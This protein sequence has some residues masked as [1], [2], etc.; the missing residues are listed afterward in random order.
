M[1]HYP[2]PSLMSSSNS[3]LRRYTPPTC[4]L[5][6]SASGSPLSRWIGRP[7]LKQL[8]FQLSLDDP[9]LPEEKRVTLKGDKTQLEALREAVE[10]Y[11]QD[12]LGQSPDISPGFLPDLA[13]D[14]T[15]DAT[16]DETSEVPATTSENPQ[17]V[18]SVEVGQVASPPTSLPALPGNIYLQSDGMLAHNLYLGSLATPESGQVIS[19][20]TLQLFDLATAFE[21]YAEE[22]V[23][24]PHLREHKKGFATKLKTAP[25]W[26]KTAAVLVLAGGASA[27][28]LLLVNRNT[29]LQTADAPPASPAP[30]PTEQSPIAGL[31]SPS[32]TLVVPTPPLSSSQILPSPTLGAGGSPSPGLTPSPNTSPTP[33]AGVT[34]SP[35]ASPTPAAGT[36]GFGSGVTPSSPNASPGGA[37]PAGSSPNQSY[38]VPGLQFGTRGSTTGA[39]PPAKPSPQPRNDAERSRNVPSGGTLPRGTLS[40]PTPDATT[41]PTN[42]V[43]T[44]PNRVAEGNQPRTNR[45]TPPDNSRFFSR[46]ETTPKAT[47]SPASDPAATSAPTIQPPP[48]LPTP[49]PARPT[50][51]PLPESASP[52]ATPTPMAAAP[53]TIARLTPTPRA[54]NPDPTVAA[55]RQPTSPPEANSSPPTAPDSS[56]AVFDPIPQVAEVR[57][58]FQQRWQPPS[59]LTQNI[60]YTL[61][62]NPDGTIRSVTPR[63]Q[64]AEIYLDRT[65][66]PLVGE[67]FVSRIESGRNTTIILVLSKDGKVD[68]FLAN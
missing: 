14:A 48:L 18:E 41:T 47:N 16:N 46:P 50:P 1:T 3:V 49:S 56:G 64:T 55:L 13:T 60:E 43:A 9:R 63:G 22:L 58:Y 12:L 44:R 36:P 53:A 39:T 30:T 31:P 2:L 33:G 8:D 37:P 52:T 65:E 51:I 34:S 26:A 27:G 25:V 15:S 21:Q 28:G 45:S 20:S 6:I 35:N 32:P 61:S 24:L 54:T 68:A 42:P 59:T 7:A 4:T 67:P 40:S 57:R 10:I 5:E 11:V 62:L 23:A 66:M 29:S 17:A 38:K 19:L